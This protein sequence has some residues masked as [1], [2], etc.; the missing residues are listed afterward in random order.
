MLDFEVLLDTKAPRPLPTGLIEE[1]RDLDRLRRMVVVD[2]RYRQTRR[3]VLHTC[4][5]THQPLRLRTKEASPAHLSAT[6]HDGVP[7]SARCIM[8]RS[9]TDLPDY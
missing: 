5:R 2:P 7:F 4:I 9:G 3:E 6:H 1:E 8:E